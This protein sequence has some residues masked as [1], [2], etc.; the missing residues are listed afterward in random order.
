[1]TEKKYLVADFMQSNVRTI[2]EGSTMKDAIKIMLDEHTNGLVVVNKEHRVIGMLSSWDIIQYVVPDYLEQ[3]RHLATFESGDVFAERILQVANDTIDKFM[4]K[5][6]HATKATHTLMEAAT[7]LSE[8][9]IR[10]LPVVDD[11][12][13]PVGY[14][15]RTDMK[16]A[17]GMVLGLIQVA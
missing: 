13:K 8:Y 17:I 16:K 14:L 11:N 6:V 9:K 1:M 4:T 15:N 2:I 10:Q 5:T 3:D 7:L 12:G